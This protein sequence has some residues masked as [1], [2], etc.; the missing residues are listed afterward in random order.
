[1]V[2]VHSKGQWVTSPN[3]VLSI[4]I[5]NGVRTRSLIDYLCLCSLPG[6][7]LYLVQYYIGGNYEARIHPRAKVILCVSA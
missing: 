6:T 5:Q 4:E 3:V 2:Y 7:V 1:M